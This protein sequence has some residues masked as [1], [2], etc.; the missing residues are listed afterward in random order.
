MNSSIVKHWG[1]TPELYSLIFFALIGLSI[2]LTGCGQDKSS[3][4]TTRAG[5]RKTPRSRSPNREAMKL[6]IS[7]C[8]Y[9][10]IGQFDSAFVCFNQVLALSEQYDLNKRKYAA[11]TNIANAYDTRANYYD[12]TEKQAKNDLDSAG[13]YYMRSLD[14]V[15]TMNDT[16]R[17]AQLL[18]DIGIFYHNTML[19]LDRSESLFTRSIELFQQVGNKSNQGHAL[20]C[21]GCLRFDRLELTAAHKDFVDAL[22]LL[23]Q[24]ADDFFISWDQYNINLLDS[25]LVQQKKLTVSEWKQVV[26]NRQKKIEEQVN[27][28]K[29]LHVVEPIQEG[30]GK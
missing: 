8:Q 12:K 4:P 21:R 2:L 1:R 28:V 26:A 5:H 17:E 24:G 13:V 16:T 14:F 11:L 6:N 3:Q 25:L 18:V 23:Q 27:Q 7:G 19:N 10:D 20:Y 22:P 9:V 15:R 30:E 29:K